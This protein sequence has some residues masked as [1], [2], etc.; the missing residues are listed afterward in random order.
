MFCNTFHPCARMVLFRRSSAGSLRNKT[1]RNFKLKRIRNSWCTH[2]WLRAIPRFAFIA[3]WQMPVLANVTNIALLLCITLTLSLHSHRG[4]S[5]WNCGC[6]DMQI[7]YEVVCSHKFISVMTL[8]LCVKLWLTGD[9]ML[10]ESHCVDAPVALQKVEPESQ[11]LWHCESFELFASATNWATQS[12][13]LRR[14]SLE[15]AQ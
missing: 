4:K 6:F 12:K 8:D 7:V 9:G 10:C 1:F 3:C 5:L 2:K 13:R 11:N 15:L 14:R